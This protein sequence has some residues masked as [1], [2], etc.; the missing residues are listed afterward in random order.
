VTV[1]ELFLAENRP[2][3]TRV[4][5]RWCVSCGD[6]VAPWDLFMGLCEA[7]EV[8]GLTDDRNNSGK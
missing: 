7:C 4:A 8:R 2:K 5:S 3:R 6:R 1:L